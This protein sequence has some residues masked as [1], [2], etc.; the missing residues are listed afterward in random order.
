[1]G[2]VLS[3]RSYF[4]ELSLRCHSGSIQVMHYD[5]DEEV[6]GLLGVRFKKKPLKDPACDV[7]DSQ[8]AQCGYSHRA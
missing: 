3:M 6:A 5:E 2:T 8:T 7:A 1:M 4:Q